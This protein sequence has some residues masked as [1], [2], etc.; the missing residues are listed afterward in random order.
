MSFYDDTVVSNERV[1]RPAPC[2][3]PLASLRD[4][5]L[6]IAAAP[7]GFSR[8]AAAG[9]ASPTANPTAVSR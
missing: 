8:Q 7:R 4:E 5:T 6:E 9:L 1:E 3:A 2:R